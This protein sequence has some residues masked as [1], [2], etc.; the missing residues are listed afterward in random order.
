MPAT[1]LLAESPESVGVDPEKLEALF[2]RAE[3]EVREGLLPSCQIALARRGKLA[4]MRSFG[5]VRRQGG[6]EEPADDATLYAVFS[7]SKAITSAAAWLLIQ[8]G[9]LALDERVADVVPEFG[10]NGK[11]LV[12][13]EHLLTH[14]AGFPHAPYPQREWHDRGAR[15]ER[16]RRWRLDWEPGSRFEYHPTSSMWVIAEL[17]ERRSGQDFREFVRARIAQPLGLD[18]LRLG[19]PR[20]LQHRLADITHVGRAL[21]PEELAELGFPEI[22]EGEVTEPAIRAFNE[23]HVREA[24]VPGGGGVMTAGDLALFYQALIDGR[25]HDGTMLWTPEMLRDARRIRT[26]DLADPW[27]NQR[28]NRGLGVVIA[29]G[30]ERAYF[31]FGRTGSAQIFGHGGAGGQIGW[32]DPESGISLGYCT[33]GFDRNQLRQARRGVGIS[34][35]AAI[36]ALPD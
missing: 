15:L 19:L 13:V 20:E 36:C 1:D 32:A 2:D 23:T 14:T 27:F 25:A 30:E 35:R 21:T 8:E 34:S 11:D 10:S 7:C 12:R 28:A 18:D 31:G 3:R 26:G 24:G 22:P 5:R 16:F 33:N 4:G 29:G 17:I 6:P 9:K